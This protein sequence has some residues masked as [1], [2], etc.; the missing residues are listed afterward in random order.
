MIFQ[1]IKSYLEGVVQWQSFCLALHR[2][3]GQ[4]PNIQGRKYTL[5]HKVY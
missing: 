1:K 3:L 5:R 4:I 2:A